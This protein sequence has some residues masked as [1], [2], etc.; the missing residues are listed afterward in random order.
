MASTSLV[1]RIPAAAGSVTKSPV[2]QPPTKT[3]SSST[4][5]NSWTT[6]S[7]RAR[8]GS[9]TQQPPE[10]RGEL[11]LRHLPLAYASIT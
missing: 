2:V 9:A 1:G 10:S 5:A 7:K 6:D 11:A 3:S 8:L 4:D